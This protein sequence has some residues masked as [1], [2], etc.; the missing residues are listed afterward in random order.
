MSIE[1]RAALATDLTYIDSLQRANLEA[2]SFYPRAVF[3]REIENSRI[4][5][6]LLNNEPAGYL[7]HGAF[8]TIL[9]IHQACIQYDARGQLYG[10]QL[11]AWLIDL[12]RAANVYSISLRCGSDIAAN[13]FWNAMGF[14]CQSV[15]PGGIRRARDINTWRLDITPQLFVVPVDP[16]TRKQDAS[17][18]RKYKDGSRSQFLRGAALQEYRKTIEAKAKK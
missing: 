9:K 7:Y 17:M 18:W 5:L 3:E 16:S 1:V 15:T 10:A 4:V 6:A 14:H 8:G 11:V 12:C 13:A 2:L